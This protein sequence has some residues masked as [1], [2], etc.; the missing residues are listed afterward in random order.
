[1]QDFAAGQPA[2]ALV[3]PASERPPLTRLRAAGAAAP[4]VPAR[5]YAASFDRSWTVTSYSA[6]V[7]ELGAASAEPDA[8]TD[9]LALPRLLRD[10]EPAETAV[11]GAPPVPSGAPWHRFPRGAHAG[12]F[13]H[14]L[15]EWLAGEGFALADSPALQQAL[16]RR[17]ERQGWGHRADEVLEWLARVATTPLPPLGRPLTQLPTATPEMEF[18]LPLERLDA[19]RVDALCREHL[20]PGRPRPPL[21]GRLLHGLLMGFADLVFE[22]DGRCGVIDH[23]SNALGTRDAD[24]TADAMAAAMLQHRYDVQAALY[25]LALQR[26]LRARLGTRFDAARH[27][28]GATFL[29][30]RGINGPAAGC[31]HLAPPSAL[32]DALDAMLGAATGAAA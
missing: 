13:L 8:G 28:H 31:L 12:N 32:L 11:E 26:L 2:I 29:F 27:L 1:L 15:L 4:L 16:R 10:D 19:E 24:Y 5:A 30:L 25:L 23:K 21:A 6:L 17:C 20:L 7:R 22:L 3:A 9:V 14:G 18:W